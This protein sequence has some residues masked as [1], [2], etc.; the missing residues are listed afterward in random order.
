MRHRPFRLRHEHGKL[1][2]AQAPDDVRLAHGTACRVRDQAQHR[3]AG[4]VT[5]AVVHRL[6]IV[7][8]EI[9]QRQRPVVAAI[10]V[11]L[12]GQPLRE[13]AGVQRTG[14]RVV[15]GEPLQLSLRA[16]QLHQARHRHAQHQEVRHLV[17]DPR[18]R[19][20]VGRHLIEAGGVTEH[21]SARCERRAPEQPLLPGHEEHRDRVQDPEADVGRRVLVRPVQ[22]ADQQGVAEQADGAAQLGTHQ[23]GGRA[24]CC[25]SSNTM[26]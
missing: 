8:I 17:R 13:R 16:A 14:Q 4:L 20:G 10:A 7:E 2:A 22:G 24:T 9:Q 21:G 15:G 3:V 11:E 5:V 26:A 19:R 25:G 6:E 1:V 18:G 23:N 12:L